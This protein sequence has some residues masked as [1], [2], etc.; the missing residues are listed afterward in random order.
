MTLV[1][2]PYNEEATPGR[3]ASDMRMEN[4]QQPNVFDL[5]DVSEAP[6]GSASGTLSP[7]LEL[8]GS[9]SNVIANG[10][11][12]SDESAALDRLEGL[13]RGR[14]DAFVEVGKA[15][16]QIRNLRLYRR[17]FATFELYVEARW[18]ISRRRAYQIMD[19]A[20]VASSLPDM[21]L[22][23][24]QAYALGKIPEEN[25]ETVLNSIAAS[26]KVTAK[27]I[28]TANSEAKHS[29]VRKIISHERFE[30]MVAKETEKFL[31]LLEDFPDRAVPIEEALRFLFETVEERII[32]TRPEHKALLASA[33]RKM[34]SQIDEFPASSGDASNLSCS[35]G[36]TTSKP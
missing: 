21:P 28:S 36:H 27:K 23:E 33:L 17:D 14:I 30:K 8:H 25:R 2:L 13:I 29:A 7:Y 20:L 16:N 31:A 10:P 22:N 6:E 5:A 35:Q 32:A 18:E 12:T 26:G 19:A 11:F 9:E 15:L 3:T 34:L 24:A 1:E 4:A